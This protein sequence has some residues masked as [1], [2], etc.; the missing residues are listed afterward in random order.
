MQKNPSI[1]IVFEQRLAT[2]YDAGLGYICALG[3]WAS[4]LGIHCPV[5]LRFEGIVNSLEIFQKFQ[6][7]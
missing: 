6:N 4:P 3:Y 5:H 2:F 7:A 1:N